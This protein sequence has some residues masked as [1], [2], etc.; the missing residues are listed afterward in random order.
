VHAISTMSRVLGVL[1]MSTEL[2]EK[3]RTGRVSSR[4]S[5]PNEAAGEQDATHPNTRS[6]TRTVEGDALAQ[7]SSD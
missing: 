6:K 5:G 1:Y 3:R 2:A 7:A 4:A